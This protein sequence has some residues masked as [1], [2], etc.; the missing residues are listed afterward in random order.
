MEF[1]HSAV[2]LLSLISFII[3]CTA[4]LVHAVIIPIVCGIYHYSDKSKHNSGSENGYPAESV[5]HKP[6]YYE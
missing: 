6:S 4:L 1:S 5:S 3:I 2:S